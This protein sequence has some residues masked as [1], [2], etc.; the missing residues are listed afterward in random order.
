[1]SDLAD[2]EADLIREGLKAGTFPYE[3]ELRKR[4]VELCK[5][6]QG[7]AS[8]AE[9]RYFDHCELLKTHLRDMRFHRSASKPRPPIPMDYPPD[10][11]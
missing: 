10:D 3:A 6:R 7:V 5:V 9:C 2:L 1:M 4:K 8:C 11:E